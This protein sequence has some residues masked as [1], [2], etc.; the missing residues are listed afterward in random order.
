MDISDIFLIAGGVV[1]IIA[2]LYAVISY[3]YIHKKC[4]FI[5]PNCDHTFHPK[6]SK[7]IFSV[8]AGCGKILKCPYCGEKEYMEPVRNEKPPKQKGE[9]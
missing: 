7:L 3:I 8:N 5:C 2:I 6:L 4:H 9:A 1:F